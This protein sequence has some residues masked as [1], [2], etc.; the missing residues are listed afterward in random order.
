M[1]DYSTLRHVRRASTLPAL[2]ALHR[3]HHQPRRRPDRRLIERRVMRPL[4]KIKGDNIRVL[5]RKGRPS[6]RATAN[7]T[8]TADVLDIAPRLLLGI[9]G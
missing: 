8:A 4:R 1:A 9:G 2:N 3:E 6:Y 7:E 5:A